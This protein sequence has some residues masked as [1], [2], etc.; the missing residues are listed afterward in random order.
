MVFIWGAIDISIYV[1][2]FKASA[3][4]LCAIIIIKR[5]SEYTYTKGSNGKIIPSS[6]AI[7]VLKTYVSNT[8][9]IQSI[10][11]DVSSFCYTF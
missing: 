7:I 2:R 3:E 9:A 5:S 8:E 1:P 4:D 10:D 11:N 6:L